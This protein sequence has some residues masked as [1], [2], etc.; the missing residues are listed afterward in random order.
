MT[1]IEFSLLTS[2]F[3]V[4]HCFFPLLMLYL[5]ELKLKSMNLFYHWEIFIL[6]TFH[7]FVCLTVTLNRGRYF[8]LSDRNVPKPCD[9]YTLKEKV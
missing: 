9:N 5:L 1:D 4:F 6:T 2:S 8:R 3:T 7:R